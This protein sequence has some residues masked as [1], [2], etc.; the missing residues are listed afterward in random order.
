MVRSKNGSERTRPVRVYLTE[1]E[2]ALARQAAAKTD[3]SVS[4]FAIDA[5]IAEARRVMGEAEK[6]KR[7]GKGR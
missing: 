7:S 4:R 5:T 6:A 2:H 3:K 1:E